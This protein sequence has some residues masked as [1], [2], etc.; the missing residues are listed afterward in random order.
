MSTRRISRYDPNRRRVQWGCGCTGLVAFLAVLLFA[1]LYAFWPALTGLAFQLFGLNR[2]G[3]TDAVFAGHTPPPTAVVLN[4][5]QPQQ[6]RVEMGQYGSQ[7]LNVDQHTYSVVTGTTDSGARV[8]MASFSEDGL[9]ALCAQH[10]PIC[11]GDDDRFRNVSIDLRPGGAVIYVDAS[12]GGMFS[13]RIGV[14][15]RL[16]DTR[17]RFVVAGVDLNGGLYDYSALPAEIVSVVDEVERVGNDILRQLAVETG[18]ESYMLSEVIIDDT[19][20]TIVMR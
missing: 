9:L 2:V 13:Q 8:A 4:A 12:V 3:E 20:L 16:D 7:T 14:V 1:G 11:R 5:S 17:T 10:S 6:V 18:G 19:T 15:L